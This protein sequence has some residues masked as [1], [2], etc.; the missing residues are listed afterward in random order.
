MGKGILVYSCFG[1]DRAPLAIALSLIL[2]DPYYRTMEGFKVLIEREFISFGH[3]FSVR[4]GNFKK[5]SIKDNEYIPIF[6]LFLDCIYQIMIEAPLAFEFNQRL[7]RKLAIHVQTAKFGTFL[8]NRDAERNANK[9]L[10]KTISL[11]SYIKN[12]NKKAKYTNE[13]YDAT[14]TSDSLNIDLFQAK[15]TVWSSFFMKWIDPALL[16]IAEL[17]ADM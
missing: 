6:I 15:F 2:F 16:H 5:N 10:E 1:N 4:F 11:W 13:L 17:P 12:H 7:L 14:K 3:R 8:C 9:V